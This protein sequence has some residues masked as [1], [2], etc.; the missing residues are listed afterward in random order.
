MV[1]ITP[2]ILFAQPAPAQPLS[3][4]VRAFEARGYVVRSA[5]NNGQTHEIEATA[6]NGRRIEAIVE[7]ATGKVLSEQPDN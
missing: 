2:A 6:P 1:L 3:T 5:E 7:A 4:S